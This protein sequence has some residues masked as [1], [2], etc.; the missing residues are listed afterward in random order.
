MKNTNLRPKTRKQLLLG[1]AVLL[2]VIGM[3]VGM[4]LAARP[5]PR[6][7]AGLAKAKQPRAP[8]GH[9]AGN[10]HFDLLAKLLADDRRSDSTNEWLRKLAS[11]DESFVVAT[12]NHPLLGH[13]AADF[14]LADHRDQ[15]WSLRDQLARGPVI[16]VFYLGYY[17]TACVHDLFELNADL[18]R[19]H[20]LGAEVVA[21][22]GD[23]P[24]LTR[25]RFERYGAFRFPV[26]S[27]PG[28]AVA[29]SYGMFRPASAADAEKLLHGTFIIGRDDTVHWVNDG[30]M[31]FRGSMTLLRQLYRLGNELTRPETAASPEATEP[32]AP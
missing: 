31:P 16:L 7:S 22:S 4:R 15:P 28:H 6:I 27:D 13:P 14:T 9:I 3:G 2:T 21:V 30:D 8:R 24:E 19:F 20:T 23:P 12:Q 11:G 25:K 29:R 1:I 18:D 26:L 32:I 17:C 5:V 10:V